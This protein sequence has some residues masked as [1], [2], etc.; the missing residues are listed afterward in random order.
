MKTMDKIA[1]N[2]S[3]Y[4]IENI[5]RDNLNHDRLLQY[6]NTLQLNK[7]IS[8]DAIGKSIEGREIK[9]IKIGHGNRKVLAWSQM[10]GDEST[11]TLAIIDLLNFFIKNDAYNNLRKTI[12]EQITFYIVP[13]LNPDGTERNTR[14]NSINIDLN[15][16]ARTLQTPEAQILHKLKNDIKPDFAFN[17]H[18]QS[19]EYTAGYSDKTAVISFLAPPFNYEREINKVR[20]RAIKLIGLLKSEVDKIIPGSVGRYSDEFEPRSFGDN[21]TLAGSSTILIES[22]WVR[23]DELKEIP[24]K[25]NFI[26]LLHSLKSIASES[27]KN[28]S[29]FTYFDIPENRSLMYDK[30]FRKVTIEKF[31]KKYIVDIGINF[32]KI[33]NE[34]S[35]FWESNIEAIGDL[36]TYSGF[37]EMDCDGLKLHP[38]YIHSSTIKSLDEL[39]RINFS[40]LYSKGNIYIIAENVINLPKHP[41]N[42]IILLKNS[43]SK[44]PE[45]AID[46]YAN[47]VFLASEIVLY[48]VING[49][50]INPSE[51]THKAING[52]SIS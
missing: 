51:K 26:L 10:H 24:R 17:L 1:N 19:R 20:E 37:E 50:V 8:V 38:G 21:F 40:E 44:H 2:Y 33:L 35:V 9:L 28:I 34:N 14:F 7:E 27:Y 15:R 29:P 13:M 48:V 31:S 12:F 49:F 4:K 52:L 5:N 47:F 3:S 22:G 36:S 23:N 32:K 46:S 45:T 18:D 25:L 11:A 42:A 30:I 16:D 39:N 41:K 43:Y 6:L